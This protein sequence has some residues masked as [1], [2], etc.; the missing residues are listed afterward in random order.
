[1]DKSSIYV[2]NPQVINQFNIKIYLN[3]AILLDKLITNE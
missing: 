1:M 3:S 2:N